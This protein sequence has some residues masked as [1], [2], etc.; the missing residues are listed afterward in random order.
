LRHATETG[1]FYV[2]D[3]LLGPIAEGAGTIAAEL[4]RMDDPL[5][6]C[7]VP[8]GNGSLINGMG[9]WLK[10]FSPSTRVI[11]VCPTGAP[12]MYTSWRAG[13][14]VSTAA[15]DTIADG[16]AVRVPVP[17]A[18]EIMRSAVDDVMLVSDPE[19]VEAMR[20]LHQDEGLVVE[21]AGAAGIA[22]VAK[23]RDELAGKRV[24][25]PLTGGNV[26]PEQLRTW[27][28]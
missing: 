26:T 8:L 5:D 25:V 7:I 16:I 21:P 9:L 2:E 23:S 24:A 22:A 1:A 13:K 14:A 19:L 4:G 18:L 20:W 11:G 3:G 28:Y 6:A 17:E 15:I 12:A 27:F 10:R